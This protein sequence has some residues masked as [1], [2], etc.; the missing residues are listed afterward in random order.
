[1]VKEKVAHAG[2]AIRWRFGSASPSARVGVRLIDY[3]DE[4]PVG[5]D[6]Q[7]RVVGHPRETLVLPGRRE[8]LAQR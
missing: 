3:D 7:R 2:L 1:M 8:L 6:Q 5:V 4:V